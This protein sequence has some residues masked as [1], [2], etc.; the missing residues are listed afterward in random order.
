MKDIEFLLDMINCNFL[1][2]RKCIT[3]APC[4][5]SERTLA[6]TVIKRSVVDPVYRL[7]YLCPW[8]IVEFSVHIY[9]CSRL[10]SLVFC[11][12]CFCEGNLFATV[13]GRAYDTC[14][15]VTRSYNSTV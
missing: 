4:Y 10:I 11:A 7:I 6:D 14:D 5:G 2:H 12:A 9:Q 3:A 1:I 8:Y 15:E 13:L